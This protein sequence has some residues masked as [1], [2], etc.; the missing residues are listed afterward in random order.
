MSKQYDYSHLDKIL[1]EHDAYNA[2]LPPW[3]MADCA[4]EMAVLSQYQ[5]FGGH[6]PN[7]TE[8]DVKRHIKEALAEVDKIEKRLRA[9]W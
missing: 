5:A 2:N 8:A 9:G 6:L 1:A 3:T 7:P 4:E